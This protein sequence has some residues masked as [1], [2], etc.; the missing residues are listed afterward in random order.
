MHQ[1]L[2]QFVCFV[3]ALS[4]SGSACV[5]QIR[6]HETDAAPQH[7]KPR[8]PIDPAGPDA[9]QTL[10][11]VV[12]GTSSEAEPGGENRRRVEMT[13]DVDQYLAGCLL[14]A[15][16]GEI[17]ICEMAANRAQTSEVKKLA[18][19]MVEEHRS[20]SRQ[21]QP[22]AGSGARTAA[23]RMAAGENLSGPDAGGHTDKMTDVVPQRPTGAEGNRVGVSPKPASHSED[24]ADAEASLRPTD[25]SLNQLADADR[26]I[27]EAIAKRLRGE[28]E[29]EPA[30]QFDVAFL[31]AQAV[32]HIEMI[33]ASEVIEQ[34]SPGRLGQIAQQANALAEGQLK[35][36]KKLL[37]E[38]AGRGADQIAQPEDHK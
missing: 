3:V 21:L 28:L 20:L 2:F 29:Q 13:F 36:V 37:S 33:G 6:G 24:A 4:M 25:Q 16:E 38:R 15:N 1:R 10:G 12:V 19:Q 31:N 18:Q 7:L 34:Q 8:T 14:A 22:L 27:H 23:A 17:A 9:P 32:T 30:E 11:D 5:A 26:R 35:Q